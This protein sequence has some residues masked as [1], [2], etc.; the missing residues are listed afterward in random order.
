[1]S[2]RAIDLIASGNLLPRLRAATDNGT[3]TLDLYS[4]PWNGW[5]EDLRA[6]EVRKG[7]RR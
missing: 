7:W 3:I 4:N 1:M 2:V 5:Y 6:P